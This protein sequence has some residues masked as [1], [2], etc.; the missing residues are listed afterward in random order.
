MGN[1]T[2]WKWNTFD[3]CNIGFMV[4]LS[5]V[6]VYPFIYMTSVSLS[7]TT[8]VLQGNVFL[9][10]KGFNL[11]SYELV[12]NDPRVMIGYVN[13]ILYTLTGT[14]VSLT[15]TAMAAYALSKR[16]MMWNKTITFLV[17]FTMFFSGGMI[18]T[19]LVVKAVGIMNTFWA[20]IL[21]SAFNVW[22][23]VMMRAFFANIPGELE[24]AG[25]MDGM[26]DLGVFFRIA[27]PLS[28]SSLATIGLFYGV[29]IW[30]NYLTPLLYLRNPEL[31]P[32]Q[33]ILR[34]IVMSGLNLDRADAFTNDNFVVGE[35]LKYATIMV[36]TIPI[37]CV[38]PFL[39]KYFVKGALIG[40]LKG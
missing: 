4:L 14:F 25:K 13:T 35:A 23:L 5:L 1:S 34:D 27:L 11:K 9:W 22:Y 40:S 28:K 10:P 39:Q 26:S 16:W 6:M 7:G 24:E 12:F 2:K 21:P 33:V 8:E 36:G 20:M 38:Y 30:N 17:V 3:V 31:L 29:G 32:L 19:F 37:L 18:P 15:L